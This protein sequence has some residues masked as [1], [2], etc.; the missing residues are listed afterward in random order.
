MVGRGWLVNKTIIGI[1]ITNGQARRVA[2]V[3]VENAPLTKQ[4]AGFQKAASPARFTVI[5]F[6]IYTQV[7]RPVAVTVI[8]C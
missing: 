5:L 4:E 1:S 8:G 3:T 7:H 6:L 2:A